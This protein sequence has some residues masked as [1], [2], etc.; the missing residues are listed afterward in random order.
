[1]IQA[2][3]RSRFT[4]AD[5]EF[6]I[7]T[8]G[9]SSRDEVNLTA[10]LTD[11][12]SRDS[13][14]DDPMLVE[15]VL[16][17]GGQLAISPQ[18]FFYVLTRHVLNQTGCERAVC[19]YVASLLE[20]FSRIAA[21]QGPAELE[22]TSTVY[23]SD[24]LM[25]LQNASPVQA[26]LIR[27]HVANYALFVSGIFHENVRKRAHRGAPAVSFYEEMGR[28]NFRAASEDRVARHWELS[29]IL[30]IIAER[31]REIRLA[32]NA[33]SRNLIG[34]NARLALGPSLS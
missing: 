23:L 16:R 26:F 4:A 28:S 15:A 3:C 18:L 34:S 12:H 22:Q 8:L 6:V 29:E 31:F 13:I 30:A 1:M 14:L 25:A 5:F 27:S 24:M 2:N 32:L 21:L 19:D 7:K 9:K 33:L 20:T 11:E 10:L 17:C